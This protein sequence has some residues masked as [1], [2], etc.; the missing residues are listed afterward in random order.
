M[1]QTLK[2]QR[3]GTVSLFYSV[4]IKIAKYIGLNGTDLNH[5]RNKVPDKHYMH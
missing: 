5:L 3:G 1:S 4:P 2:S